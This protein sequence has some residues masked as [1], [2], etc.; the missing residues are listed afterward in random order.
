[1]R[2]RGQSSRDALSLFDTSIELMAG[3]AAILVAVVWTRME[4]EVF[5]LLL[6]VLA[7]LMLALKRY[8]EIRLK[9]ERLV[10]DRTAA[11]REKTLQLEQL[12]AHDQLTG[13]HNR[14]HADEFLQREFER[15]D[16]RVMRWRLRSP[17]STTSRRSTTAVPTAS[18]IGC[19]SAWRR[20]FTERMRK[21]D[22]VA[23]YGGEEFLFGFVGM[24]ELDAARACEDCAWPWSART[25][26]PSRPAC[27]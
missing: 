19:S 4:M 20:I 10:E 17:T 18:A 2:V 21:C 27:A 16:R 5:L 12:A 9:L 7:A 3:L 8:A 22:L 23:R 13:L 25:G 15:A 6:A 24:N 26:R 11:L 1:M 14:R